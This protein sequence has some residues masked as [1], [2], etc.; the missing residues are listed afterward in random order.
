MRTDVLDFHK[1]YHSPLGEMAKEY[2]TTILREAWSDGARLS[3][4]GFGYANP[5]LEIFSEAER[6]L[7]LSP[8]AQ[9][10]IRWPENGNNAASLV[11]EYA[12]PLPDACLDRVLIVHGLEESPDPQRLMREIWRILAD[13]G[14]VI[15]IASNRRGLWS[16]FDSTPFAAG[17]PY[18]KR[19][20][21]TLLQNSMFH[22]DRWSSALFFP[23]TQARFLLRAARAWERAG[24]RLWPGLGGVWMV[25]AS[26]QMLAPA[27]LVR[28]AGVRV[29]RPA[30][31]T[32]E[33]VRMEKDSS[34]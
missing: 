5:F 33:P 9:G 13:D 1:F 4:A 16:M 2:I 27:G 23:P 24:A 14:R 31:A 6:R 25:E 20:L 30:M 10:V 17:R 8:G 26:K 28:R 29:A 12:W 11:G 7:A 3:I 34:G 18:L 32:P 21:N 15:I 22:A 19:Q